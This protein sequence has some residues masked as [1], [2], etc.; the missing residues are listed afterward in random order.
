MCTGCWHVWRLSQGLVVAAV[1]ARVTCIK[2]FK[3]TFC[4]CKLHRAA[5]ACPIAP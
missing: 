4:N 1:E 2:L 5:A 3:H